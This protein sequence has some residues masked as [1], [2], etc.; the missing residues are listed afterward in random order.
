M[1]SFVPWWFTLHCL[2][3][4]C[5]LQV[6]LST[7]VD[8]GLTSRTAT[9]NAFLTFN[10]PVAVAPFITQAGPPAVFAQLSLRLSEQELEG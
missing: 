4:A 9:S 10:A 6:H 8:S 7:Y 1:Y 2:L 3:T 5:Y